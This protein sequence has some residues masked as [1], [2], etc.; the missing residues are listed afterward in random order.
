MSDASDEAQSGM[1]DAF[2]ERFFENLDR[3]REHP[4]RAGLA[5]ASDAHAVDDAARQAPT[6]RIGRE[7]G[8]LDT[9]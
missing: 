9:N 6:R 5:D 4:D 3:T 2:V 7:G 8:R 1:N